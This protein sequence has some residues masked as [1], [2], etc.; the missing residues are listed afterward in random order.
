MTYIVAEL[1]SSLLYIMHAS[2]EDAMLKKLLIIKNVIAAHYNTA[3]IIV[4]K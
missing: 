3:T 1:D 2:P 4:S